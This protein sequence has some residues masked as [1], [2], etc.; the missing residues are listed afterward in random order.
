MIVPDGPFLRRF[1]QL[2]R[3]L[4]L[5]GNTE[6][7]AFWFHGFRRGKEGMVSKGLLKREGGKWRRA[8]RKPGK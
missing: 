5:A 8:G 1:S 2:T 4:L 3:F 6:V 7:T